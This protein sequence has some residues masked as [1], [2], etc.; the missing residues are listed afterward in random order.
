MKKIPDEVIALVVDVLWDIYDS[1][2]YRNSSGTALDAL[3]SVID[4]SD[5]RREVVDEEYRY[6]PHL[7]TAQGE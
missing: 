7:T 5:Y 2:C 4:P 3:L 6:S 1:Q